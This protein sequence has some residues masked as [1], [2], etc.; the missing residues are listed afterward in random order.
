MFVADWSKVEEIQNF[1]DNKSNEA[2]TLADNSTVNLFQ[3]NMVA[4]KV[5]LYLH[6]K[7]DV[8]PQLK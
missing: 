8:N 2:I 7:S 1:N 5:W 4:I 3:K 6:L